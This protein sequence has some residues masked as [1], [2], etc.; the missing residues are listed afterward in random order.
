MDKTKVITRIAPSP[1]GSLHIGTARTALF[2]FLFA[3]HYNGRF[4][5]RIEDT[6]P[7]RSK[8]EYEKDITEGLSWLGLDWDAKTQNEKRKA[9]NINS[10]FKTENT[11]YYHQSERLGVY[12]KYIKKLLDKDAAYKKDNAIWFKLDSYPDDIIKYHDLIMGDLEFKKDTFN[13]FVLIKSDGVPLY[14]FAAVIDDYEMGITHIIRG[15]DHIN[16]TPQQ[17]MLYKVLGFNLP[18]FAHIPLILN[19]DRTKMS[20]RKNPVSVGKDFRDQ[21]YLPQALVNYMALLGWNPKDEREFFTL[22]ELEKEFDLKNVNKSGAIFDIGKL[23]Y[24]NNHYLQQLSNDKLLQF[25]MQNEKRKTKNNNAKLKNK[26]FILRIISV[27]KN[28]MNTLLDFDQ[29]SHYFF[30]LPNYKSDLLIFKKSNKEKTFRGLHT[31]YSI[32]H[33]TNSSRWN[34]IND[35]NNIL[36]EVVKN[37]SLSNG[38][39]FWPVRVALS[40]Q[41]KSPSPP[42]LLWALGKKESL[43][44]IN[45]AIAK[46]QK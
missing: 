19:K 22:K 14:M 6:D 9:K 42:E 44:R 34:K 10:K 33:T 28:R 4:L 31:T 18:K 24:F 21:G 11:N 2:N 8:K 3:K 12:Q 30:K 27:V 16:S 43:N 45:I 36:L 5:L 32:L 26:E 37:E 1:T 41:E 15:D 17:I 46:S 39:V 13:D 40:G 20:K 7:V 23:N 38:D 29:L 25:I 35:L